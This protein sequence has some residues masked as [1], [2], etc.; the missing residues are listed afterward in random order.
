MLKTRDEIRGYLEA[1][2]GDKK[3]ARR[4]ACLD[5]N[6]MHQTLDAKLAMIEELAR[7]MEMT[8]DHDNAPCDQ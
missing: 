3:E 1:A 6:C 5:H 2:R 4:L 7:E 8:D